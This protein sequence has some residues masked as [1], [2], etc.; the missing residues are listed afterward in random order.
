MITIA[1]HHPLLPKNDFGLETTSSSES[2]VNSCDF[3][4]WQSFIANVSKR[5]IES[6]DFSNG[7]AIDI[8]DNEETSV[9]VSSCTDERVDD[10]KRENVS[11]SSHPPAS[12]SSCSPA[13]SCSL[14][15]ASS[16]K[17][18]TD[19]PKE[20]LVNAQKHNR[21][22]NNVRGKRKKGGQKLKERSIICQVKCTD[23][24]VFSILA[25]IKGILVEINE[26]LL[27][28]PNLLIEEVSFHS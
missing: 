23:G 24:S 11:S 2:F 27:T 15:P 14:P 3:N 6:I 18:A 13:P 28:Q 5:T 25:G 20:Q 4:S 21:L 9:S 8:D 26:A 17:V 19:I 22:L 10:D 1:P 16:L 7:S 12:S